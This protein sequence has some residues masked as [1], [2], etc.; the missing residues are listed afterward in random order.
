MQLRRL[1]QQ[2]FAGPDAFYHPPN[3]TLPVTSFFGRVDIVPFPFVVV[4]RYDQ[5]PTV[6]LFLVD[7]DDLDRLVSQNSSAVVSAS[8]KVRLALRALEG[9]PVHAP[10]V[11]VRKLGTTGQAEIERHLHFTTGTLRIERN[12]TF[13][14]QGYNHSSGFS[15]KVE[16]VDGAGVDRDG[17]PQKNLH[18]TLPGAEFGV[19]DDFT[20][21]QPLAAL[22]R[23]NR[24]LIEQRLPLVEKQLQRHRDFFLREAEKKH[25]TLSHSFLLTVFAED[26]L[27][28][29]ELDYLLRSTEKNEKVRNLARTYRALFTRLE[30]RM[31]AVKA[32]GVR[33]WW[34][35][36]WDD[37]WR[38]NSDVL[39]GK[40]VDFSP[41]YRTSICVRFS[42]SVFTLL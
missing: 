23:R 21:T 3:L 39:G 32:D 27:A 22:F 18:L 34:A 29:D 8:R 24:S 26:S 38:R 28:L 37:L 15:V 17:R 2:R 33:G 20:L 4:F 16:Y 41:F 13:L 31:D 1:I 11:E 40:A 9:Q 42:F 12:S 36:F 5:Q 25:Q 19:L 35:L 7:I 14:W 10:H 6:P 30:E